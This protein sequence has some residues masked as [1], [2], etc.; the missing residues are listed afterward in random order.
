V[1]VPRYK[2]SSCQTTI[3]PDLLRF[4]GI[5]VFAWGLRDHMITRF[6]LVLISRFYLQI[7]HK[8]KN[9]TKIIII[10]KK[11]KNKKIKKGELYLLIC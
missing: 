5:G 1:L 7:I 3:K 10:K 8:T 6:A 11:Q 2:L 4:P 9:A